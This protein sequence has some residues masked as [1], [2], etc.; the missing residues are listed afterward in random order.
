MAWKRTLAGP[1]VLCWLL[2]ASSGAQLIAGL[3]WG[4]IM[5]RSRLLH[6]SDGQD[7][8][9]TLGVTLLC[10]L[11]LVSMALFYTHIYLVL[12][13]GERDKI[14]DAWIAAR[15]KAKERKAKRQ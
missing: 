10:F 11:M 8:D 3:I 6:R 12:R 7:F 15:A 2:A 9:V 1:L 14:T 5:G 4:V 13:S